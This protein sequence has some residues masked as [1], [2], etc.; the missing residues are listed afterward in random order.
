[1]A[2]NLNNLSISKIYIGNTDVSKAFLGYDLVFMK[3]GNIE[4]AVMVNSLQD[5]D[6]GATYILVSTLSGVTYTINNEQ[7]NWN[8]L[9]Y[10][11]EVNTRDLSYGDEPIMIRFAPSDRDGYYYVYDTEGNRISTYGWLS[12]D[13]WSTGN[14]YYFSVSDSI[15]YYDYYEPVSIGS[16][17]TMVGFQG[18]DLDTNRYNVTQEYE[19]NIVTTVTTAVDITWVE[20][21]KSHL[22]LLYKVLPDIP[23]PADLPLRYIGNGD[24]ATQAADVWFDTQFI[25]PSANGVLRVWY[26]TSQFTNTQTIAGVFDS[27]A[28]VPYHFSIHCPRN[29]TYCAS[30]FIGD[31]RGAWTNA[32]AYKVPGTIYDCRG[33]NTL[34]TSYANSYHR[35][36]VGVSGGTTSIIQQRFQSSRVYNRYKNDQYVITE[37]LYIFA[38]R[39]VANDAPENI[40]YGGTRI[41]QVQVYS[42]LSYD[43]LV[44]YYQPVLHNGIPCFKE[45]ISGNYIYNQGSGTVTFG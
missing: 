14:T 36:I 5:F 3:D 6:T 1:M 19:G 12:R 44:A 28:S 37:P 25:P 32:E 11:S 35:M 23:Y 21:V 8:S 7:P 39:N 16:G 40:C 22:L 24:D 42:S 20:W 41:Y 38:R 30:A 13:S 9:Y 17:I 45:V 43:D 27:V 34:G 18:G 4:R 31:G 33:Y 10:C 2:V 26:S 29:A 15:S